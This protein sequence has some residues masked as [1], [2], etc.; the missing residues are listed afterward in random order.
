MELRAFFAIFRRRWLLLL[1]PP[2]VVGL[3]TVVT[4][5]PPPAPGFNVGV[6]FLVAQS[7]ASAAGV[8]D[9]ERYFNWLSSEYIVNGLTD[10][11]VSGSFKTAV[12]TH[13]AEEAIDVPPHSFS[14]AADNVRSKLQVSIQHGD[15]EALAQI[16]DAAIIVL[17]E[18][19]ADALP[20]LGGETAVL[21]L[22]DE[23]V[24]T[25]LPR[26]LSS[27]LDIPLRLA[28][29]IAAGLGLALLAEYLDPTIRSRQEAETLG[30]AIL[31]EIP[32]KK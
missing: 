10:W 26:S 24:V 18:Q 2:L 8:E 12:S 30:F 32:K 7:P 23:P 27:L 3:F 17:N 20:Q 15:A 11:A 13:L 21:T 19:N 25:P 5:Q 31:G 16:M 22:L 29:G 9:E 28:I 1:I 6:N 14:V 4:F